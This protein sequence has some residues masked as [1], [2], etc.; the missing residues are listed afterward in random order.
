MDED[1]VAI[2]YREIHIP[3][4]VETATASASVEMDEEA[5]DDPIAPDSEVVSKRPESPFGEEDMDADSAGVEE[6]EDDLGDDIEY[7]ADEETEEEDEEC[8]P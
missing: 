2:P 8:D 1:G 5:V 7:V 3:S 4:A 6:C